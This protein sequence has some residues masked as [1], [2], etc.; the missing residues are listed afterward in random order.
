MAKNISTISRYLRSLSPDSL[1]VEIKELHRLFP[2]VREYYQA[3]LHD[4]GEIEL[5]RKYKKI[6]KDEFL[7]GWGPGNSRLS[8]AR[9]AVN[10]FIKVSNKTI[11]IADIQL[12]YVEVGVLFTNEYGDID[13]QFYESMENMYEKA[14]H[15]IVEHKLRSIFEERFEKIVTDTSDIG[16]GFP[17]ALGDM[18][19]EIFEM[20]EEG[21]GEVLG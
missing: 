16:W 4:D 14:G 8:V 15:Y 11:H 19:N 12:Y 9:K 18:Y 3:K 7:P 1:V 13:E 2:S 17:D 10:D 6:I 21:D 20:G 5:L